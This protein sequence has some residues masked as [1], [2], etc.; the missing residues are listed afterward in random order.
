VPKP[1]VLEDYYRS[2][3][4]RAE[5]YVLESDDSEVEEEASKKKES[6]EKGREE[7]KKDKEDG[8]SSG[9]GKAVER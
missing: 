3:V 2:L 5:G 8:E 7:K 6:K 4:A 1:E 9:K